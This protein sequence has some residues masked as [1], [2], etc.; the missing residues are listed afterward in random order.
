M[1]DPL[2]III[3]FNFSLLRYPIWRILYTCQCCSQ[4]SKIKCIKSLL[5]EEN[6]AKNWIT[7]RTT[8]LVKERLICFLFKLLEQHVWFF[9]YYSKIWAG[10]AIRNETFYWSWPKR[11][12]STH[13]YAFCSILVYVNIDIMVATTWNF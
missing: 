8:F 10:R 4:T 11:S 6:T 7:L 2:F 1:V 9:F 3:C 5:K 12:P 13:S